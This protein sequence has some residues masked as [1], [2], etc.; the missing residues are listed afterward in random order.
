MNHFDV[1]LTSFIMIIFS[2]I[3]VAV[4]GIISFFLWLS[5]TRKQSYGY[6]RGKEGEFVVN[7]YTLLYIKYIIKKDL[8]SST[9]KYI[10]Y[11]I[12][13]YYIY[14]YSFPDSFPL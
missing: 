1:S 5:N 10:N 2:Y 4:N 7:R 13:T 3:Y 6:Q 9:G 11:L 12:I 8:L 14:I